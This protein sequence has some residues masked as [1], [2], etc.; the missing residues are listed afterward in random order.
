MRRGIRGRCS[1]AKG[2]FGCQW[3]EHPDYHHGPAGEG[4]GHSDPR[5]GTAVDRSERKPGSW[6]SARGV[7]FSRGPTVA[8]DYHTSV[9]STVKLDWKE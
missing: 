8:G 2:T 9:L 3:S 7:A 4:M 6:L 5:T 1:R